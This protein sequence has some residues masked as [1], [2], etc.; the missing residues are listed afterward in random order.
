MKYIIV[1]IIYSLGNWMFRQNIY[2]KGKLKFPDFCNFQLAF[3]FSNKGN[4]K[5]HFL[6][7]I[8]IIIK[9]LLLGLKHY[10]LIVY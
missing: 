8:P 4:H 6:I 9:F 3:E 10:H 1:L 5:Y 7:I 2:W